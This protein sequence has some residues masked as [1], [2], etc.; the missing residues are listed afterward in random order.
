VVASRDGAATPWSVVLEPDGGR[1]DLAVLRALQRIGVVVTRSALSRAFAAGRVLTGGQPLR[2]A[3]PVY[4]PLGVEVSLLPVVPLRAEPEIIE[5][6]IVHEDEALLVIDKPAG[7]PVHAGPGHDR[8]TL[9][10]A[11]LGHLGVGPEALPVLAGN[12]ATRPGIVHRLDKDTSGLMVVAK[13]GAAQE[14]LAAQFRTHT[15]DRAYLGIVHAQPPW[16]T[17]HL[18]TGHGRDP[19]DRRRFSGDVGGRLATTDASVQTRLFGAAVVRF[20]LHTGRTHQ[21][22]MHARKLGHPILGDALYGHVPADPRVRA[23]VADLS[24]HALHAALLGFVHPDGRRLSWRSPL[25][26]ELAALVDALA[27]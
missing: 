15:I 12:D 6:A 21:I 1:A 25:P 13:H 7:M 17:I 5:L 18:E 19:A 24:R 22:R 9:V 23:A 16:E 27:I 20:V 14:H 2:A 8:G 26:A 4:T 11:V 10:N 3:M